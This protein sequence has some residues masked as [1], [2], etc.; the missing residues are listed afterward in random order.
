MP[1]RPRTRRLLRW[2]VV[3][4]AV[5][6]V[7]TLLAACSSVLYIRTLW[8]AGNYR[9][10]KVM[11]EYG[12]WHIGFNG[13]TDAFVCTVHDAKLRVVAER[14]IPV[15]NVMGKSGGW[16]LFPEL[17]AHELEAVDDDQP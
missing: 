5:G 9:C 6:A 11:E 17:I 3:A 8:E 2:T 15:E 12:G 14:E 7:A 10:G 16:P 13:E 4:V 1:S